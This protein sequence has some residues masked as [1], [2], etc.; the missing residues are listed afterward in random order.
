VTNWCLRDETHVTIRPIRPEDEPLLVQFHQELSDR[1]VMLRYFH[2]INLGARTTHERLIRVC[3]NNYDRD[4][5]L[6]AEGRRGENNERFILGIG[7]LSKLTGGKEAEF[8]VVIG[9]A[10]QKRGLGTELLKRAL[11]VARDEKIERLFM[12]IMGENL[13]MQHVAENFGFKLVRNP[14]DSEVHASI[15]L[16]CQSA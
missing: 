9:D 11:Q 7:R 8:S 14:T 15:D 3:F 13:E 6:V 5:A 16:A 1:T 10:F 12:T 2:S 4:L